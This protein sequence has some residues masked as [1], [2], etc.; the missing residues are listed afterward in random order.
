MRRIN[1]IPMVQNYT[2]DEKTLAFHTNL[3]VFLDDKFIDIKDRIPENLWQFKIEFVKENADVEIV[4]KED[5]KGYTLAAKERVVITSSTIENAFYG[6][7]TLTQL[8]N[9]KNTIPACEIEDAPRFRYRGIMLDVARHFFGKKEIKELLDIMAYNKMNVFHWHLT[10][11]QGWRIEIKKY[12]ELAKRGCVRDDEWTNALRHM[13]GEKY[14]EGMYFTQEDIKEIVAYAKDRM[15][16]VV[17]EIDMPGH[18]TSALSVFPELSCEGKPLKVANQFGVKH[19]IGCVGNPDFISFI[20]DVIDEVCELFPA[21]YFHIGGDE[22]PK[23]KW[24]NCPKCQALMKQKG[25]K[26]ENDLQGWFTNE[27]MAYLAE[28][29]KR[30]IGW[31]EIM[32]TADLRKDAIVQ[33]WMGKY[34]EKWAERGGNVILS[35][36]IVCYLDYPYIL[37]NLEK[38]YSLGPERSKMKEENKKNVLGIEAP[39]WTEFVY[40]KKKYDFMLY[41]RVQAVAEAAWTMPEKKNYNDFEGRLTY[42]LADLDRRGIGYCPPKK[43]NPVGFKG[44]RQR[45]LVGKRIIKDPNYEVEL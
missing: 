22:V 42:A 27:I 1:V 10:E 25:I 8:F 14:G 41:P 2:V 21:P 43:Y 23:S 6:L 9:G 20:K 30:L 24:K 32:E 16:T 39:L 26:T 18:I 36:N 37:T 3:K 7:I 11:D 28:K 17:P 45:F 4:C 40:D 12:P 35:Q 13:K 34:A 29:G 38:I 19:T 31:N 44:L 5:Q 33:W 15:I